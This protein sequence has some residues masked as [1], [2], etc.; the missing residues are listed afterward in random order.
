[1][2]GE[3]PHELGRRAAAWMATCFTVA[4]GLM[5]CIVLSFTFWD[6]PAR[7]LTAI[8]GGIVLFGVLVWLRDRPDGAR[9]ELLTWM[10][11]REDNLRH[12]VAYRL[13][14]R[15]EKVPPAAL[16]TNAPPS[17][18]R[19]REIA[20]GHNHWVPSDHRFVPHP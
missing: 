12:K 9:T 16:G 3:N 1:M 7:P 20:E 2:S 8:G 11:R 14:K 5:T 19:V 13:S 6:Q 17:V 18:E 10:F 15:E 4:G